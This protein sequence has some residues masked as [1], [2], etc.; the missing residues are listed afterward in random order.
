MTIQVIEADEEHLGKIAELFH[1]A[2][3]GA[4]EHYS[5]AERQ[6]W[7]PELRSLEQWQ[8][9][10]APTKVWV[11]LEDEAVLGFIN[12]LPREQG[13]AEIDCLFTHPNAA[14]RGIASSLYRSLEAE[15][16]EAGFKSLRVEAS[17]Y[18][19][20]FFEKQGFK[21]LSRNEHPRGGETLVNFSMTVALD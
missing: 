3:H 14:R 15:A 4:G 16:R 19:K 17:F 13:E 2:V 10:L 21:V 5:Q 12:L 20:P 6:A 7:S 11:A 1:A 8:T 18:A 9:R